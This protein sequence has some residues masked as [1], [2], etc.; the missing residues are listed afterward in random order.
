MT[1][2]VP[3]YCT[4]CRSRC[5]SI[6]VVDGDRLVA[7]EPLVGH[8][9]G[10]ALCAKGRAAPE[11]VHSTRRLT[12]PL[13]RVSSRG[14]Q[15]R[16][17]EI[18]WDEALAEV[19]ERLGQIRD[20]SGAEAVAFAVTTP[21]GTPMVDS[22]EWV[23]RFIRLFGSPN[24][25][26]AVEICGWHKDYAHALTFGRG[27]GFP[28][29]ER[30]DVVILW[31]H[32]PARTWLA[33]STRIAE[34][35]ER[36]ARIAV[37]DPSFE[38][39]A[40]CADL[41]VRIRPGADGALAMGAIRHLISARGYDEQ[42]LLMWTNAPF[43]VDLATGRFIRAGDI[44][45]SHST[46][47]FVVIGK[48]GQPRPH[49]PAY[50]LDEPETIDLQARAALT[51]KDGQSV[52]AAT[53]FDLLA[54]EA[55]PYTLD[56]VAA[57]TW[58]DK[59]TIS[60]F[61]ALFENRPRLAYHAWTGVGQ[62]SNAT[63]T[64][65]AIA[66]LYAMT[67]ACDAP[68]GNVFP[69]PPP[70]RSVNGYELLP[71]AQREKALGLDDLPLGPPKHGWITMRDF[72]DA[73]LRGR[74][75][76]VRALMSF[77]TNLV[78][79][80]GDSS[81]NR[82]ALRALDYHVHVDMF[83]NPTAENAD[84]VLPASMPWEHDA[85]KIGFEIAQEAVETIQFRPRVVAPLGECR[86]DYSIVAELATRLGHGAQF[87]GGS[88]EDGWN[89]QLAPLQT[90]VE[91][92]RKCPGGKRF[93][94]PFRYRKYEAEAG[95][96]KVAGFN[97]PT[98]RVE[99][100]S[101]LLLRHGQTPI[102]RHVE[103]SESVF[104]ERADPRFPFVLTTAK[105][106]R[107]VHSSYR[108]VASLRSRSP[109]PRVSMSPA[110]AARIGVEPDDWVTI[111][112]RSGQATLRA[113]IDRALDD[114]VAVAEFG[115]WEDCPPLGMDATTPFGALTSNIN[116][117]LSDRDR[118]PVSGS[119]PLRA[120]MCNLR[121]SAIGGP[122]WTG[123]R[124]FIV[125]RRRLEADDVV[126]LELA[127]RDGASLPIFRPGQHVLLRL[128]GQRQVRAY[129][130]IG[131][132]GQRT[133]SIAVKK[134]HRGNRESVS[135][136]LHTFDQEGEVLLS[137]PQG[138]FTPPLRGGRPLVFIAAGIGITPFIGHLE[139]LARSEWA[140]AGQ[141]ILLLHGCR[142][143]AQHPF[144]QR[145]RELHSLLPHLTR[146]TAYSSPRANDRIGENYNYAG[147]IDLLP[148]VALIPSRPLV[149]L[150]GSLEFTREVAEQL[151]HA[152]VPSFDIFA[153]AFVSPPTVPDTLHQQ[154]IHI[155]G[156]ASF[157]WAPS[158]GSILD[159][160]RA[161]GVT[162]PSGCR[163]G[164][165]ETCVVRIVKGEVVH[166]GRSAADPSMCLTCQAAPLSELTLGL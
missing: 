143:G 148:A 46:D 158:M 111:E 42:F 153:E 31:G 97:T 58:V 147:R 86:P 128:P 52:S 83:M 104:S 40:Q 15:P 20:Q 51:A 118:D 30:A 27:I 66:T 115:W 56:H 103:P 23:E 90:T 163:A 160:A 35:R 134:G 89:Y 25:I 54:A 28:D 80:Q 123:E 24:L 72:R 152:G 57:L 64:E 59:A 127:P 26:Y 138:I 70:T 106:A 96:G 129:S 74:P 61:F 139:A 13:R 119:V 120:T 113:S 107:F 110:L 10:N 141:H 136:R 84:L 145:L 144:A 32:N 7:V 135:D 69:V 67:G 16:W 36:G 55:S 114:R 17:V 6:A 73:V 77:G 34:A 3:G 98:R 39:S 87:F 117:A 137:A 100:Y 132:P 164:Q 63:Q 142:N 101:E 18:G 82:D 22:F 165:C 68:G 112:T 105:N 60:S 124:E 92:L 1:R 88:I 131:A 162:L 85:L 41:W 75:Y 8:P 12:K 94:Q 102:A 14:S 133:L 157:D 155:A 154:R 95:E 71:P 49:D 81:S 53:A 48:D 33:Q 150:C 130:L 140:A 151:R 121:K 43:L 50:K 159:A 29:L 44:W 4:L 126:A 79:T 37:V 76:T 19:A 5:G 9:T 45:A 108:H 2:R 146:V 116:D 21:S 125:T 149:Y 11:I 38:G 47:C 93:P 99:I 161:A 166:F 122:R 78:V 91:Q 156:G 62:H 65:R 109:D